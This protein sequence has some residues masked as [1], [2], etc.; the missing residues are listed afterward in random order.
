M[1]MWFCAFSHAHADDSLLW[2]LRSRAPMLSHSCELSLLT[3]VIHSNGG[4]LLSHSLSGPF[5]FWLVCKLVYSIVPCLL[6]MWIP[7]FNLTDRLLQPSSLCL[8]RLSQTPVD[9]LSL[10][11]SSDDWGVAIF[12]WLWCNKPHLVWDLAGFQHSSGKTAS[13]SVLL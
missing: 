1:A 13:P 9:T 5:V 11:P 10:R 6:M 7:D 12:R 3:R 8:A 2:H 4:L